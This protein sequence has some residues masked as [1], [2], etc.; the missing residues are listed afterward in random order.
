MTKT[1]IGLLFLLLSAHVYG[2]KSSLILTDENIVCDNVRHTDFSYKQTKE[3]K[4]HKILKACGWTAFGA[5]NAM[6]LVGFMGYAVAN[7]EG[8]KQ[9]S[10]LKI[11]G[12]IGTGMAM[13][14][15]P[16]LVFSYINEKKAMAVS[17][18]YQTMRVFTPDGKSTS[19]P[20]LSVSLNF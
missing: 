6:M 15:I 4:R 16:L 17:A 10:G 2:Q 8:E 20:G 11:M 14:S 19:Q 5:G 1:I 9:A 7:Y 18:G 3:W 12:Y 13:S